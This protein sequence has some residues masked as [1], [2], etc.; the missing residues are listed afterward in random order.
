MASVVDDPAPTTARPRW[1]VRTARVFFVAVLVA[2]AALI[3]RGYHDPHKFF[4]FQPFNESDT[5]RADIYRI[6]AN[7]E[8]IPVTDGAW[9]GYSWNELVGTP[10]LVDPHRL[11]H[12]S[13]GAAATIDFLDGALDWVADHTP[14]DTE[15]RILEAEVT[16]YRNTRGPNVTILR[17]A[18]REEAG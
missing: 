16:W 18:H 1:R 17:S 2:Q 11:R 12:A 6:T 10:R 14:D 5:W 9:L 13:S 8:R 3:L 15:T 7:G 4:G